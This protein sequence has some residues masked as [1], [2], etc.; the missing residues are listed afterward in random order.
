MALEKKTRR[1]LKMPPFGKL[2]AVIV[3]G[4]NQEETEKRLSGWGK[5][6]PIMSLFRLSGRAGTD[7]YATEQVSVSLIA[8]NGKKYTHSGCLA[9]LAEEN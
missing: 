5:L 4:P 6:L 9:R 2:A 1:L 8:E 7:F 3:S